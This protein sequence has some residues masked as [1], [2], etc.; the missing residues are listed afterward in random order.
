MVYFPCG[1]PDQQDVA[2][3]GTLDLT[4]SV[5][6][7]LR[8]ETGLDIGALDAEFGWTLVRDRG[9]LAVI[10]RVAA[11]ETAQA[12]RARILRHT[13]AEAAPEF[14]DVHIIAGRDDLNAKMPR[15]AVAYLEHAW[16]RQQTGAARR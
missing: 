13:S 15:W 12:L 7:E 1:T 5:D 14:S 16:R 2:A 3:D 10:K 6:R 8:E 9:Y 4:G 11:A